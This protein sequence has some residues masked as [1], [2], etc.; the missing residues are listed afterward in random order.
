VNEIES[1]VISVGTRYCYGIVVS[2]LL[3]LASTGIMSG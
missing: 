3:L 1:T 2:T